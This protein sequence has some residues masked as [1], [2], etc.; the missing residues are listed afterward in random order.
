MYVSRLSNRHPHLDTSYTI[1]S[2]RLIFSRNKNQ[3]WKQHLVCASP[4]QKKIYPNPAILF[5]A[6]NVQVDYK[7]MVLFSNSC[8]N[9][10]VALYHLLIRTYIYVQFTQTSVYI[11]I[12]ISAHINYADASCILFRLPVRTVYG[13][14]ESIYYYFLAFFQH[15]CTCVY[16]VK[17]KRAEKRKPNLILLFIFGTEITGI[18]RN[19]L[20]FGLYARP[21]ALFTKKYTISPSPFPPSLGNPTR[22]KAKL[23]K[24]TGQE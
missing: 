3:R 2:R 9:H 16:R 22:K 19:R 5:V 10:A 18:K 14:Y 11:C 24:K 7:T 1:P 15:L 6:E 4:Y 17:G 8:I 21:F 13:V 23:K 20:E 12:C